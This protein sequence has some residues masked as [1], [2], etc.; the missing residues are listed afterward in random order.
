MPG[1]HPYATRA[2]ANVRRP[3]LR[4][5]YRLYN[6]CVESRALSFDDGV[7]VAHLRVHLGAPSGDCHFQW[8]VI[9]PWQ[10][11]T[12]ESMHCHGPWYWRVAA[13]R[14]TFSMGYLDDSRP[15]F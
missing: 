9:K 10:G 8:H 1:D 11:S 4:S 6:P 3:I 5:R 14:L 12:Y 2:H 7:D 15:G 13:A